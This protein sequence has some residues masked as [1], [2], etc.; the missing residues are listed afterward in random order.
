[1]SCMPISIWTVFISIEYIN[2]LHSYYL[3][4]CINEL[5]DDS[6]SHSKSATQQRTPTQSM[7]GRKDN[8]N[9]RKRQHNRQAQIWTET[10]TLG[11]EGTISV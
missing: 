11:I 7:K 3:L 6:V 5:R 8:T 2:I 1:M 10:D 4:V 9:V